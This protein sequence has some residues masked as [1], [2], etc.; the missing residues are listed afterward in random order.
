MN[1][2]L[3]NKTLNVVTRCSEKALNAMW[4]HIKEQERKHPLIPLRWQGFFSEAVEETID[5]K[6]ESYA[7]SQSQSYIKTE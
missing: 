7:L 1:P 6:L 4:E 5:E 3:G 2:L